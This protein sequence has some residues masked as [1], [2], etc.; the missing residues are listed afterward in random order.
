MA[1]QLT[2]EQ[3][4]LSADIHVQLPAVTRQAPTD[5]TF[6]L[7][8]G[9]FVATAGFYLGFVALMAVTFTHLE[10]AIP[11]AVIALFIVGFFGLPLVWT[12]LAPPTTS[13]A[14]TW[15]RFRQNGI[16]TAYG[17]TT[18]RD[19]TVQVLILPTLIF[20]WGIV[21]VVIAALV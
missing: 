18:A 16:M 21:V 17:R 13:K 5:R 11:L 20:V 6:E 1:E 2:R 9:L 12:R 10:L 3:I 19:A 8:T 14:S 4:A 7:P 15:D